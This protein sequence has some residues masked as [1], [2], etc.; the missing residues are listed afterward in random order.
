[1]LAS[2][3]YSFLSKH[4]EPPKASII[5]TSIDKLPSRFEQ[6]LYLIT[7]LDKSDQAGSHWTATYINEKRAIFFDSFGR[8]PPPEIADFLEKHSQYCEI[9]DVQVQSTTSS[10]CGLFSAIALIYFH[11]NRSLKQ[12]LANFSRFNFYLNEQ[13][14]INMSENNCIKLI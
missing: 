2:Q 14:I 13:I 5:V 10:T 4:I 8:D 12:Y 9:S 1:M 6:P 11:R 7:N 3:V